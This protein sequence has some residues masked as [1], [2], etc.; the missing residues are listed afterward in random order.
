MKNSVQ[1]IGNVGNQPEVKELVGG[2]KVARFSVAMNENHKT[3]SGEVIKQTSWY[4]F[5][6]WGSMAGFVE[7]H[8]TKGKRIAVEGKLSNRS[9]EDPSGLKH[10]ITEIVVNEVLFPSMK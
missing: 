4:Q 8:V 2:K 5:V 1:I 9:Y 3:K 7:R 10:V 6:A